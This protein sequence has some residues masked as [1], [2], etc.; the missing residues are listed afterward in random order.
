MAAPEQRSQAWSLPRERF[1]MAFERGEHPGQGVYPSG[2]FASSGRAWGFAW[3]DVKNRWA[4]FGDS[5]AISADDFHALKEDRELQWAPSMTRAR[6]ERLIAEYDHEQYLSQY[7][8][9]PVAEFLGMLPPYLL[10]PV[11]IATL[12]IGGVNFTRALAAPTLSRF[13]GHSVLGGAKVGVASTPLEIALQQRTYGEIRPEILAATTVAPAAVAPLMLAPSRALRS[14]RSARTAAEAAGS[15]DRPIDADVAARSLEDAGG[16]AGPPVRQA[17]FTEFVPV[18]RVEEMFAEYEGGPRRW[19][20]DFAARSEDAVNFARRHGLDPESDALRNLV[21]RQA[22]LTSERTPPS[23]EVR[24]TQLQ[25]L[26]DFAAGRATDQQRTRLQQAGMLEEA[27]TAAQAAQVRQE[28]RVPDAEQFVELRRLDQV[29]R[30]LRSL[31]GRPEFEGLVDA[32]RV[33]PALRTTEQRLDVTEF[34][35][36]G[37]DGLTGRRLTQLERQYEGVLE[38]L[39]SVAEQARRPGRTPKR[40]VEERARLN[41][42][43]ERLAGEMD[44]L[45]DQLGRVDDQVPM[46]ELL[47]ALDAANLESPI[48]RPPLMPRR[49]DEGVSALVADDPEIAN[50]E[51]WSR[52]LGV[53]VEEA[54]AINTAVERAMAECRV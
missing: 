33:D 20:Q 2:F 34:M 26:T 12:P 3:E 44:G 19:L 49:S 22:R 5:E 21:R 43:R 51:N 42:E 24:F 6:A 32:L 50:L 39:A 36:R 14:I 28:G 37:A 46:E 40:V 18:R 35:K 8:D 27:E 31:Q 17:D 41:A 29:E 25:D 15:T 4:S 47:A 1:G 7:Q 53:D 45:Y 54:R 9:R 30:E 11:N 10:D 38:Q 48:V 23:A 52:S 13:T 16:V